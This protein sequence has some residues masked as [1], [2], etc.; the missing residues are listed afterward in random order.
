MSFLIYKGGGT[1]NREKI[2]PQFVRRTEQLITVR[3]LRPPR[4]EVPSKLIATAIYLAA[5]KIRQVSTCR[6]FYPLRKQWYIITLQRV[7]HPPCRVY[8]DKASISSAAGCILF[9]NDDIQRQ[10]VDDIRCSASM[11]YTPF[12]V[13]WVQIHAKTTENI[14]FIAHSQSKRIYPCGMS[15]L[16]YKEGGLEIGRKCIAFCPYKQTVDNRLFPFSFMIFQLI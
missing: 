16:I 13:I 1:W 15:F 7:S 6:I 8:L 12:G 9:R 14:F 2:A 5:P 3:R 11:I 10:A 4:A